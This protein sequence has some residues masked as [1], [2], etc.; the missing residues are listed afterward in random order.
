MEKSQDSDSVITKIL[1]LGDNK[2][3]FETNNI[4]LMPGAFITFSQCSC[5]GCLITSDLQKKIKTQC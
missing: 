3:D 2:L 1:L 5:V 4:L